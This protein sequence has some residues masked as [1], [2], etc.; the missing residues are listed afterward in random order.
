[1]ISRLNI[2]FS[3]QHIIISIIILFS[4]LSLLIDAYIHLYSLLIIISLLYLFKLPEFALTLFITDGLVLS[5]YYFTL[6][7]EPIAILPF[8][9]IYLFIGIL[10]SKNDIYKFYHDK[11][12][13]LLITI[14]LLIGLLLLARSVN[15]VGGNYGL[16]KALLYFL[17]NSFFFL[18]PV[19]FFN[20]EKSLRNIHFAGIIISIVLLLTSLSSYLQYEFL[21]ERFDPSGRRNVIWFGRAM[22]LSLVWFYFG[23]RTSKN[24]IQRIGYTI[25]ALISMFLLNV[26]GSRGPL[27][28]LVVSIIFLGFFTKRYSLKTKL[29]AF[30]IFSFVSVQLMSLFFANIITRFSTL[31]SDYSSIIRIYA[32]YNG[33]IYFLRQPLWGWGT[34]SFSTLVSEYIKYPHNIFVEL[35]MEVGILGLLLF[36]LFIGIIIFN[37]F[38]LRQREKNASQSI[39]LQ[40]SYFIF[41][42]GFFNSQFSGDIA[43]NPLMWFSAG[44]LLIL[45]NSILGLSRK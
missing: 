2:T 24:T 7:I 35:A 39:L 10:L 19:V 37:F 23:F 25:L 16:N 9:M 1:L 12:A 31:S 8:M 13:S 26:T 36:F 33:F 11:Q 44:S 27:V 6:D 5:S 15:H 18:I 42:F 4:V 3:L 17:R 21:G 30:F 32:I 34:G 41:L 40:V 22:G 29:M 43:H 20:S 38:Y 28:A 45:R 14:V